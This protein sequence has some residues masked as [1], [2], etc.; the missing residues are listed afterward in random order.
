M[1][2]D[3]CEMAYGEQAALVGVLAQ[4]QPV[5]ALEIGTY[6][7]GSLALIAKFVQQVHT[8]DLVSHVKK[9]LPNVT[10]HLGDSRR[11]VP[12]LLSGFA[13]AGQSVDFVLIDGDHSRK[14][15]AA[16]VANLLDSPAVTR[17][18]VLLHDVAN[19][20]V[21]AGI[22]DA[23]LNRPKIA[24]ANLSFV[25]PWEHTPVLREVWGG[26]GILVIDEDGDFWP[27][28]RRIDTNV[29]WPTAVS[30]SPLWHAVRPVRV[31]KRIASYKVRPLV[32]QVRGSRGASLTQ[33]DED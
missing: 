10:Y 7:G 23:G 1:F 26:L 11:T 28:E 15:V 33:P 22:R 20:G 29:A 30:R 31:A 9:P 27:R 25:P 5:L 18:V 6:E 32:R 19:E 3:D 12:A 17:A 21:R 8:F 14:G 16:D 4:L 13:A 2:A 24:Y